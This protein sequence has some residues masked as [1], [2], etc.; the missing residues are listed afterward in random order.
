MRRHVSE[1]PFVISAKLRQ[2]LVADAARSL[3]HRLLLVEH[4]GTSTMEPQSLQ[5]LGR[6]RPGNTLE[7]QVKVLTE[8]PKSLSFGLQSIDL[9][10][11]DNVAVLQRTSR[12]RALIIAGAEDMIWPLREARR[13]ADAIIG[14]TLVVLPGAG[15]MAARHKPALTNE[16]IAMFLQ[17]LT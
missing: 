16:A 15:H 8:D 17:R 7:L 13:V 3:S 4:D 12:V 6:R 2:T 1:E 11:K 9:G 10:R 5:V 14:S